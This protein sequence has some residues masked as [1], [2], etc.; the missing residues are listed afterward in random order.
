MQNAQDILN[1]INKKRQK[2]PKFLADDE[3]KS[4]FKS[5]FDAL[6]TISSELSKKETYPGSIEIVKNESHQKD[7]MLSLGIV[8]KQEHK[9]DQQIANIEVLKSEITIYMLDKES[10]VRKASDFNLDE[11]LS[12]VGNEIVDYFSKA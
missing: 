4:S 5:F 9:N 10:L 3:I 6:S 12:F 11:A 2:D 7:G 8:L 1:E